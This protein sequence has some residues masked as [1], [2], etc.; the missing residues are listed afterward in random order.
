MYTTTSL[1]VTKHEGK[2]R[3]H[4]CI[5]VYM[6]IY[7]YN[8]MYTHMYICIHVW[9]Y[10][11]NNMYTYTHPFCYFIRCSM[12]IYMMYKATFVSF[13][14]AHSRALSLAC[15]LSRSRSRTR[16]LALSLSI[17]YALSR[18]LLLS[19]ILCCFPWLSLFWAREIK[20]DL[21]GGRDQNRSVLFSFALS[22]SLLIFPA[23][24]RGGNSLFWSLPLSLAIQSLNSKPIPK[25]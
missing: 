14:G 12:C 24:S 3:I 8:N 16:T 5:Y 4:I 21:C 7:V 1:S 19:L 2:R 13:T 18:S 22:R 10:V 6:Y 17:S 15:S 11:Y 20:S 25:T 23:L 9:I